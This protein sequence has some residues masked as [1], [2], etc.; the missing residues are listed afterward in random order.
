MKHVNDNSKPITFISMF[1][2]IEAASVAFGPLGWKALC[3]AEIEKF[4]S[5][6]LAHHYPDVP[7]VGDM[8]KHD[9]AQYHGKVDIVCGGPPCQ[10]F[11]IAGLRAGLDGERGSLSITYMRA[12]HAIKPRNAIIENVTGWLTDKK[13]AFGCF[14]AGLVG[15]DDPLRSPKR[16]SWPNAGMVAGPLGRAAWRVLDAKYFGVAQQ[17]NRVIVVADFG[18]GADPSAVLFERKSLRWH[19]E[20]GGEEQHKIAQCTEVC[21]GGDCWPKDIVST[22]D[23]SLGGKM[24]LDNQHIRSGAPWFVPTSDVVIFEGNTSRN[25]PKVGQTAPTVVK[26]TFLS[27]CS[28]SSLRR[29]TPSECEKLQGFPGNHTRIPV[30]KYRSKRVTKNRPEHMWEVIDGEWWLMAADTPRYQAIGN[31][32]AVPK[33]I[34][35][36]ERIQKLMPANDNSIELNHKRAA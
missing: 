25:K 20:E 31:S 14:L 35:L 5:A 12:L 36:G 22:L 6:V 29:L 18:E 4:P 28:G 23:T 21:A 9:W 27:I 32:W 8:S 26:R 33:F 34:W 7:N 19:F 10:D 24:G 17:R 16:K 13:N 1:S 3:F 30:K 2:G 15:A 11:S